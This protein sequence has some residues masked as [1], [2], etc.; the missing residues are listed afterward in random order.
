MG[1]RL[2][3][4]TRSFGSAGVLPDASELAEWVSTHRGREADLTT[5]LLEQEL[6]VQRMVGITLP[7]AGGKFYFDR[8]RNALTGME[9]NKVIG[10][11]GYDREPIIRDAEEVSSMVRGVWMAIPAPHLLSLKD[12]YFNDAEE[13]S[14]AIY[15]VYRDMMRSGRDAHLAGHVLFCEQILKEELETLAGKKVFFFSPEMN[16]KSLARCLEFQQNIAIRAGMLPVLQELMDEYEVSRIT[17]LDPGE[18]DLR[19]ALLLRDPDQISCGGY[20]REDC[21]EYWK[22]LVKKS[23][24]L[25]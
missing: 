17:L 12:Q 10:E 15:S 5:F 22:D 11:P 21:G 7:C 24:I 13:V 14:H 6:S 19:Q 16:R 18:D 8:W 23:S 3:F 2:S 25:T 1:K 4:Q 20:C 9:H